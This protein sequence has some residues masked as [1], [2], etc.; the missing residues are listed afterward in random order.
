[1]VDHQQFYNSF[2]KNKF[3]E[4]LESTTLAPVYISMFNK[5]RDI[6]ERFEKDIYD[7]NKKEA[8]ILFQEFDSPSMQSL[9]VYL[10][11][12]IRYVHYAKETGH[13]L[14]N[15]NVFRDFDSD[16]LEDYV[17]YYKHSYI[18]L[19][20]FTDIAKYIANDYDVAMFRALFEGIS[21]TGYNELVNLKMSDIHETDEGRFLATLHDSDLRTREP[22]TREKQITYQLFRDLQRANSQKEYISD[23]GEGTSRNSVTEFVESPYVFKPL[24]KGNYHL[25]DGQINKQNVYRKSNMLSDLTDGEIANVKTLVTSGMMHEANKIFKETG[26]LTDK[27]LINI[28]ND[29]RRGSKSQQFTQQVA[30]IKD[31]LRVGLKERYNIEI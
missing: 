13:R 21:G 5:S 20:D 9:R 26:E 23:N 28:A 7:F 27:D 31:V 12:L 15:N 10:S 22:I 3:L 11:L 16:K 1:M 14:E 18:T 17:A 19:E 6:E 25:S 8:E 2:F 29:Y 30:R 4:T 24:K